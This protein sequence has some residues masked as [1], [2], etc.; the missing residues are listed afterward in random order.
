MRTVAL[1]FAPSPLH[2]GLGPEATIEVLQNFL[3]DEDAASQ[4]LRRLADLSVD[5]CLRQSMLDRGALAVVLEAMGAHHLCEASQLQGCRIF[6][7]LCDE[8]HSEVAQLAVDAGAL[9]AIVGAMRHHL[10]S[11]A[12]QEQGCRAAAYMCAG[13]CQ[14]GCQ[15]KQLA[16]EGGALAA[17]VVGMRRH[18]DHERVQE[19]AAAA[20]AVVCY[21]SGLAGCQRKKKAAMAGALDVLPR[22]MQL[23]NLCAQVQAQ[24]SLALSNICASLEHGGADRR[25]AAVEAGALQSVCSAM[26]IHRTEVS[27]QSHGCRALANICVGGD[28]FSQERRTC[29]VDIGATSVIVDAMYAHIISVELLELACLALTILCTKP[30]GAVEK[31]FEDRVWTEIVPKAPRSFC[32]TPAVLA[33]MEAFPEAVGLQKQAC[34]ALSVLGETSSKALGLVTAAMR[35]HG[36]HAGVQVHGCEAVAALFTSSFSCSV[37]EKV[38]EALAVVADLLRVQGWSDAVR[39][40]ACRAVLTLYAVGLPRPSL[41]E[42][43]AVE[44]LPTVVTLVSSDRPANAAHELFSRALIRLCT[45]HSGKCAAA[46]LEAG[47][48][49]VLACGVREHVLDA[50]DVAAKGLEALAAVFTALARV[51]GGGMSGADPAVRAAFSTEAMSA[52]DAALL[53]A[54]LNEVVRWHAASAAEACRAWQRKCKGMQEMPEPEWV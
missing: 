48:V 36:D 52:V 34:K 8:K 1:A 17:I 22:T 16:A 33:A 21:G 19:Q 53:G 6:A 37:E 54:G 49:A 39:R 51:T 13:T 4:S 14:Q 11:S 10:H 28:S 27:V 38:F 29:A 50:P 2:M 23:H 42:Q 32:G 15:R 43:E 30:D 40:H 12:L 7:N 9:P 20:I 5:R 25:Q 31:A 44:V 46:A 47:A 18:W 24:C 35:R 45:D 26:Q 3:Q 41:A